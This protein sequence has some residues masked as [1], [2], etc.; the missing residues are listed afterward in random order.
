M[1]RT[2]ERWIYGV[3]A[4]A[5]AL[6]LMVGARLILGPAPPGVLVE[7]R[8][9]MVVTVVSALSAIWALVFIVRIFRTQDEFSRASSKFAWYWGGA[10][11]LLATLPV[12]GFIMLGGLHWLNP[13]IPASRDLA[14]AFQLGY[15]LA[16]GGL[17]VGM[18]VA[19]L[20][21]RIRTR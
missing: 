18:M 4:V 9:V 10:L 6:V 2:V 3:A 5:G 13:A 12:Y 14:R 15:G 1:N 17:T 7:G 21:W 8:R 16:V 20:V 11:G 19:A